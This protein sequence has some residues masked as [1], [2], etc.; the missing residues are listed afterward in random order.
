MTTDKINTQIAYCD[1]FNDGVHSCVGVLSALVD[2]ANQ[3]DDPI[4]LKMMIVS[5]VNTVAEIMQ[6][7]S[8][9][10]SQLVKEKEK[11]K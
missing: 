1:G 3:V 7:S 9:K 4:K 5:S 11:T 10:L 2:G 6:S 8:D